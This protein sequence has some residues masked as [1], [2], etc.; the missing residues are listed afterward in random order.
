MQTGS[1]RYIV[2]RSVLDDFVE[3]EDR[4]ALQKY[5]TSELT[6]IAHPIPYEMLDAIE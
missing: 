4:S 2:E 1:I 6:I 5:L 3:R